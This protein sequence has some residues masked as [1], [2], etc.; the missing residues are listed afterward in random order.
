MRKLIIVSAFCFISIISMFFISCKKNSSITDLSEKG[1]IVTQIAIC[2][3]GS[4]TITNMNVG[5]LY[6][7]FNSP[8]FTPSPNTWYRASPGQAHPL[9]QSC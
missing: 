4:A 8:S 6:I 9:R 3:N 2:N 1:F 5:D 7:N